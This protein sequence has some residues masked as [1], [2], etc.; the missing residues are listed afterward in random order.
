MFGQQII[1]TAKFKLSGYCS[2]F[3][4]ELLAILKALEF[5]NINLKKPINIHLCTD[6]QTAIKALED[7]RS[8]TKLIQQILSEA[9]IANTQRIK[10]SFSWIRAHNGSKGNELADKLAKEGAIA[11]RSID[12][13]LIPMS[14][15][16]RTIYNR[17]IEIWN[18]RWQSSQTGSSTRKYFPT[19]YDRMIVKKTFTPSYYLTQFIT[20]HGKFSNYLY[21]FKLRS[22]SF[23]PHCKGIIGEA[24]HIIY[25]CPVYQEHRERLMEITESNRID[26]PCTQRQLISCQLFK[27]FYDFCNEI[28]KIN[29]NI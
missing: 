23:C 16:K 1:K 20:N 3:Q 28:F 29:I 22:D 13:E 11:H 5:T 15:I 12:Y 25:E 21:R 7:P 26:W 17:N 14:Y 27:A 2:V 19:V 18:T 10:L 4:A 8:T 24:E 6:S 9:F